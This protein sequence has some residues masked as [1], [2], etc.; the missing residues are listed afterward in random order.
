MEASTQRDAAVERAVVDAVECALLAPHVG[1]R[2]EGTVIDQNEHGVVVQLRRP[3]IV[4]PMAG[5]IALGDRVQ[6]EVRAVD[7]VARRVE[8]VRSSGA[9]GR[10]GGELGPR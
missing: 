7:P 8:L 6:V 4:A 10:A 9:A 5:S 2:F 1:E 3:A